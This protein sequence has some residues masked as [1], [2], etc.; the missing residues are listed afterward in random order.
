MTDGRPCLEQ[1]KLLALLTLNLFGSR[2]S[3]ALLAGAGLVSP[4]LPDA[5]GQLEEDGLVASVGL[6]G[7]PA[8]PGYVVTEAGRAA[9]LGSGGPWG[10]V[11]P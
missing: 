11:A 3:V 5:L 1:T 10:A 2:G 7:D 8:R 4:D 6:V 9:L